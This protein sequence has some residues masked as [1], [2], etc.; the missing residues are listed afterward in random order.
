MD[1]RHLVKNSLSFYE[2]H[3][4]SRTKSN[5]KPSLS[6][7][8][9]LSK[10]ESRLIKTRSI[11]EMEPPFLS[12]TLMTQ[13]NTFSNFWPQSY[14]HCDNQT[15]STYYPLYS[16]TNSS[17]PKVIR[18]RS[19]SG[20]VKVSPRPKELNIIKE[21]DIHVKPAPPIIIRQ[22][23]SRPKTPEPISIREAPP[24]YSSSL[25]N[26]TVTYKGK[27]LDPP[28]RR[29]VIERMPNLP[30]KPAKLTVDRWLPSKKQELKVTVHKQPEQTY[31]MPRNLIVQWEAEPNPIIRREV[32]F[33]GTEVADPIEYERKYSSSFVQSQNLPDFV[34]EVKPPAGL[35]LAS[36]SV[37]KK[38]Y[39]L[40]GDV[41]EFAELAR[42][43][44]VDL[45]KE[46]LGQFREFLMSYSSGR[47]L[48]EI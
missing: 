43:N 5:T 33:L 7:S 16:G 11:K 38:N 46:G 47:Y 31:Q 26:K 36:D 32:T 12:N 40:V 13:T 21:A 28:Q 23:K 2:D 29:V 19:R 17:K 41:E 8:K 20:R 14:Y 37:D 24:Q 27:V 35:V 4:R 9:T 34:K 30:A 3:E 39:E 48:R 15:T 1:R 10:K 25:L 6:K 22:N 45:E 42:M 44:L 18:E